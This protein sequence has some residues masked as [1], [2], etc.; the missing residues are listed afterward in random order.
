MID[1]EQSEIDALLQVLS[2]ESVDG[3]ALPED[4]LRDVNLRSA[5]RKLRGP[6]PS[7]RK[8]VESARK[9]REGA[10][11]ERTLMLAWIARHLLPKHTAHIA[12]AR[13]DS[14]G[15]LPWVVCIHSPRGPMAWRIS[16]LEVRAYFS[17]LPI[18]ACKHGVVTR[19]DKLKRLADLASR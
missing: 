1:L 19:E 2:W 9:S 4:A 8:R 13:A 15:M 12:P 17:Q 16:D 10:L 18:E 3:S 11:E 14:G 7:G 5:A 6:A